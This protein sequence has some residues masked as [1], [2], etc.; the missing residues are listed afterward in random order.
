MGR[1]ILLPVGHVPITTALWFGTP[2][3]HLSKKNRD[4]LRVRHTH[5]F[6]EASP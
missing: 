3:G 2:F 6:P 5:L 4:W 1:F